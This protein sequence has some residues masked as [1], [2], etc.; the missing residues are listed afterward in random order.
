MQQSVKVRITWDSVYM[1]IMAASSQLSLTCESI[2]VTQECLI[3]DQSCLL[4]VFV[5][6]IKCCSCV[7]CFEKRQ[8]FFF[9]LEHVSAYEDAHPHKNRYKHHATQKPFTRS[10]TR[11]KDTGTN[12]L[13]AHAHSL[14]HRKISK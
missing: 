13:C 14:T 9:K 7:L 6:C 3:S 5:H 10:E 2:L 8:V 4:H 12:T 11:H 1:I